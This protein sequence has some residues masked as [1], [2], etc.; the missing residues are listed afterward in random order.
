MKMRT[1][2]QG[3]LEVPAI[4]F[5]AFA[6]LLVGKA[7]LYFGVDG[8]YPSENGAPGWSRTTNP[9]I[10]S[11]SDPVHHEPTCHK[12]QGL[13]VLSLLSIHVGNT[14]GDKLQSSETQL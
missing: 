3:S 7:H 1:A 5:G 10:R 12:V 13:S 2:T 14:D 9:Q 6:S 11:S 4:F 8:Q